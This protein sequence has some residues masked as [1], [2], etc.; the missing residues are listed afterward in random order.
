[1]AAPRHE[2]RGIQFPLD[3]AGKRGSAAVGRRILAAALAGLDAAAAEACLTERD[4]RHGY[5][6]HV[7]RLVELQAA[8]PQRSVDACRAGL[9]AAWRELVFERNGRALRLA[10]ALAAPQGDPWRTLRLRGRGDAAPARWEVPYQGQRLHGDALAR[11]IDAWATAGVIEDSAA[12]AL[13]LAR[14]HPEWFDLS[15]RHFVLL[16]AGSEAGPLAWLAQWR[17]NIV[18]VDLPRATIWKRIAQRVEAGNGQLIAP[19]AAGPA[20]GSATAAAGADTTQDIERAGCDMLTHTPELAAWLR[21]LG[22]PLDL[23]CI[24]YLDGEKHVRVTLAMDALVQ[25]CAAADARS[26]FA[27][28][29]TP[30]DV[31]ALPEALAADVMRAYEHRG[32]FKRLVQAGLHAG[33][34][35]RSFAPHIER[36]VDADNG[37]RWG[38]ADCLVVEQGPNYA[39]AKRL[40]QWRAIVARADGH[41]ASIHVAPSTTTASVLSNPA[42]A[43]GFRGAE[44]FDIEVFAPDTTNALMAAMWVHDLRNPRASAHPQVPLAHP[45]QLLVD[46]A[47]HGG[48]W[49]VPYLPRSVLPFAAL[50]GLMKRR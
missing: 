1:M 7:V 21:Q 47:C 27:W 39:L 42:L 4:W 12:Q 2:A 9:D 11:R 22:Q 48:L 3:A 20:P 32:V 38:V 29:A 14:A 13:Q 44:A 34:G 5:P 49:R 25:A 15:D 16:G 19:L 40:Q 35:G 10:D 17:A 31:F 33:S 6:K 45:L 24:A 8:A 46:G 36:L 50:L 41:V 43:A 23:G 30:T 28:L 37:S 18:A 26:S